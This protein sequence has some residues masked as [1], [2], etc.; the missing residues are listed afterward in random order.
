MYHL[1]DMPVNHIP[2]FSPPKVWD[3]QSDLLVNVH[4][5]VHAYDGW[6]N[7]PRIGQVL[8]SN[9]PLCPLHSPGGEGGSVV[10]GALH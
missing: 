3:V 2:T 4:N 7:S 8:V 1:L 5:S 10:I 6:S 9:S